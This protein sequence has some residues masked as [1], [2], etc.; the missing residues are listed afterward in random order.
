MND[1]SSPRLLVVIDGTAAPARVLAELK[2][3][4]TFGNHPG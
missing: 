2:Q 4:S 1:L 3:V